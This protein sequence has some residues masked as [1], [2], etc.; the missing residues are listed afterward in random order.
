MHR[1]SMWTGLALVVA[2]CGGSDGPTLSI[3]QLPATAGF[4]TRTVSDGGVNYGFQVFIPANYNSVASV[5]VILFMHG[6][7]AKGSDNVSQTN[8]GLGPVVK[9]Q[10]STFPAIVVF[11]QSP[12]TETGRQVFV[13][14][15]PAAL[16]QVL[17]EFTKADR[18]R[19]YLT[20][21]SYGAVHAWDV[22]YHRPTTFAAFVPISGNPCG[23]CITGNPATTQAQGY[24]LV[25]SALKTLPIWQFQGENDSQVSSASVRLEVQAL[26]DAGSPIVYTQYASAPHEIWDQVYSNAAMWT[27]LYAQHR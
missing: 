12:A 16:D 2:A 27:W 10:A 22:A 8:D 24:Q 13:R 14:I 4:Q 15:A 25:A 5:P 6:S 11:P 19:I 3:N 1:K 17:A 18:S 7:G 9:A 23:L 26:K 20:G 21:L